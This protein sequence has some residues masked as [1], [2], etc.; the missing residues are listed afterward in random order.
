MHTQQYSAI[1]A[2]L[3]R[4]TR[5][6]GG[7][8]CAGSRL[9]YLPTFLFFSHSAGFQWQQN[10]KIVL[11]YIQQHSKTQRTV[12]VVSTGYAPR[13]SSSMM[14]SESLDAAE[15][16]ADASNISAM[17][18]ET[19]LCCASPAPTLANTASRTLI[20]AL[21][22]GTKLPTFLGREGRER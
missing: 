1:S 15:I 21:S 6:K 16:I 10:S 13:P 14:M 20:S 2:G 17:K 4:Q 9:F 11:T 18:V 7:V 12:N 22:Q 5:G 19:P 3:Y 8:R